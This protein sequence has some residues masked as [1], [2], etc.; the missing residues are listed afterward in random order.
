MANGG[1][2]R[3]GGRA[4]TVA[5]FREAMRRLPASPRTPTPT[6]N[7]M[8]H[9]RMEIPQRFFTDAEVMAASKRDRGKQE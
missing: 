2:K 6:P 9:V 4:R 7:S 8:H 1:S 3:E 5:T